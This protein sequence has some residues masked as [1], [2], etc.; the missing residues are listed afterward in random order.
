MKLN[1]PQS[2]H[3]YAPTHSYRIPWRM[4]EWAEILTADRDNVSIPSRVNKLNNAKIEL[5]CSS[6]RIINEETHSTGFWV[7]ISVE[8]FFS[9]HNTIVLSNHLSSNSS[10]L[11]EVSST[12]Q[13][14]METRVLLVV[15]L[16]LPIQQFTVHTDR[17]RT[18]KNK[19]IKKIHNCN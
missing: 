8:I 5:T 12:T 2:I 7:A 13:H 19:D 14:S 16:S 15:R 4:Y 11:S 9:F 18:K 3:Q 6:K 17:K 10:H 1:E